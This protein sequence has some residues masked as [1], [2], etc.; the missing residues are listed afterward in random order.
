V[1][2]RIV[3]LVAA[4]RCNP[5]GAR[6]TFGFNEAGG[7]TGF[8][9]GG[10]FNSGSATSP[11]T[12]C[13]RDADFRTLILAKAAGNISDGSIPSV[14]QILLALFHGAGLLRRSTGST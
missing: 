3:G 5:R 14:N 9:Q 7:W 8:N 11:R 1:W 4:A 13:C 10:L 6:R 12:W 2:G